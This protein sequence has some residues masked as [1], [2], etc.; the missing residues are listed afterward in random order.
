MQYGH[1]K[2]VSLDG[3]TIRHD[4]I[5]PAGD[6]VCSTETEFAAAT[7]AH[8]L[9]THGGKVRGTRIM[10]WDW[11]ASNEHRHDAA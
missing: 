2:E 6:V 4:V 7:L 8:I 1:I 3:K 9:N 11:A 10:E 5:S